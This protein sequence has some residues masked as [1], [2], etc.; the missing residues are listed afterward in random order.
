[1]LITIA[2]VALKSSALDFGFLPAS[3][4]CQFGTEPS[5]AK[6]AIHYFLR[7]GKRQSVAKATEIGRYTHI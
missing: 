7:R 2:V 4:Q 6:L 3:F 1:M 5:A